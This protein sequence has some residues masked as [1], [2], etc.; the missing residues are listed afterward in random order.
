MNIKPFIRDVPDFPKPGII[1]RD[2]TPL[3]ANTDAFGWTVNELCEAMGGGW[4]QPS[5]EP[6]VIAAIESRGF[7]FGA[8]MARYERYPLVLLR[9]P[10]K[11]PCKTEKVVYGKEYGQDEIHIHTD[12]IRPG[13]KVVVVDD[14]LATGGTVAAAC[15][16]IE[17]VGG[18][19]AGCIFV[20]ELMG[21][22]GREKLA[23][24]D[25]RSLVQY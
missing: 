10:G 22:G 21:L 11:L 17:K 14:L 12:S 15:E 1:F 20:I 9:K 4:V 8:A 5:I 13:Q 16:L 24:R 3:L 18:I 2:I 19:V 7:I 23:G 6:D 25:V